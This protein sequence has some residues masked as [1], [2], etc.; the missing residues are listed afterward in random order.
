MDSNNINSILNRFARGT[1]TE[2]DID[3]LRQILSVGD[4]ATTPE[5]YRRDQH[6]SYIIPPSQGGS[7]L[8]IS[9]GK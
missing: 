1:H 2:I 7:S 3:T 6:G 5:A 4:R 9:F 8:T